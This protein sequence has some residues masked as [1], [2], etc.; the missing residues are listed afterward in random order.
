MILFIRHLFG[1]CLIL[2]LTTLAAKAQSNLLNYENTLKFARYLSN[3]RQYVFAA[4]EYERLNYLWPGDTSIISELVQTYRLNQNCSQFSNAYELLS[5]DNQLFTVPLY[6]KEYLRFCLTCKVE[7]PLYVP[8][9]KT[10]NQD[11]ECFY[12]LSYLWT[13][14]Q[15]DSAFAYNKLNAGVISGNHRNLYDL[16]V[17]FEQQKYKKPL[18][19]LAMSTIIPGSGKAYSKRWG[20]AGVSL[21]LVA[22][23]AFASYRAFNQKGIKS[24]NGWMFG[25]VAVSFYSSNLYGSYKSAKNYNQNLRI[26]YQRNAEN[27]IFGS[28]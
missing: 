1:I 27:F 24:F 19:A 2:C 12:T 15:Y 7:H 3:T 10:M 14:Q 17:A 21:I 5:K 13:N 11:D 23:S 20:D 26:Q 6:S 16:T 18:L 4:E 28:F 25:A 9:A 8:V 22:S